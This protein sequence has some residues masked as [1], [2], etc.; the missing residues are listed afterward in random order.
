ML[1]VNSTGTLNDCTSGCNQKFLVH[2]RR[3]IY[4]DESKGF[5][6][7]WFR[8][9]YEQP[10]T[11]LLAYSPMI[12]P[13]YLGRIRD[14][15]KMYYCEGVP[16]ISP[17]GKEYITSII[18]MFSD[19]DEDASEYIKNKQADGL[20]LDVEVYEIDA[21]LL[22]DATRI[23][24]M[25]ENEFIQ[26]Q[27]SFIDLNAI[28][29]NGKAKDFIRDPKVQIPRK[30]EKFY[31]KENAI[32]IKIIGGYIE[33]FE[34]IKI[35]AHFSDGST[36][37]VGQSVIYPNNIYRAIRIQP[38][39]FHVHKVFNLPQ[40]YKEAIQSVMAQALIVP[41]FEEEETFN[42][43]TSIFEQYDFK[44][45]YLRAK[46][47]QY[48]AKETVSEATTYLYKMRDDILDIYGTYSP[49][50]ENNVD[51][52]HNQITYLIFID[53]KCGSYALD[54]EKEIVEK[55]RDKG[56]EIKEGEIYSAFGAG[57]VTSQNST[58]EWGNAT[59]IY[60]FFIERPDDALNTA[61]H[62]LAH[63]LGL[64]HIFEANSSEAQFYQA[65][66]D[67]LMD[68]SS[69]TDEN[70]DS[71][72]NPFSGDETDKELIVE[73]V[74]NRFQWEIMYEDESIIMD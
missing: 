64:S 33:N 41:I 20:T 46:N 14:L 18:S 48:I 72:K 24:F 51:D 73:N 6:F 70:Y 27:P 39:K 65:T 16:R 49:N 11:K 56:L 1:K 8:A 68:Y 9:E 17:Y 26:I 35:I 19:I 57:G 63:S 29:C 32:N 50:V 36:Q 74:L 40:N 67:N 55:R 62:E 31:R 53:L 23:E 47:E 10:L 43:D 60:D 21:E 34:E 66:T 45:R 30:N 15:K 37:Q 22:S 59:I 2:L 58:T 61:N 52:N 25:S 38:V 71:H 12:E 69:V 5:G 42:I 7:D 4:F 54:R 44:V 28:I 3:P 13:I